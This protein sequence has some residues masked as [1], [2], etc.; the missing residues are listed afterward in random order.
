MYLIK[1]CWN[2]AGTRLATGR[3][4]EC[5]WNTASW[6]LLK[7]MAFMAGGLYA[8][9][10]KTCPAERVWS[11]AMNKMLQCGAI[12]SSVAN[13]PDLAVS[14]AC[15]AILSNISY[16]HVIYMSR[17]ITWLDPGWHLL[18]P[19]WNL[20]GPGWNLAGTLLEPAGTY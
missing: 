11:L 7:A 3:W 12:G 20:L 1:Q 8:L 16:T 13:L 6:D 18:Q 10:R 9:S 14:E 19:C 2:V 15:A 4:L 5:G 17:H